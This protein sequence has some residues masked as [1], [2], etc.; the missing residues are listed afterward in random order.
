MYNYIFQGNAKKNPNDFLIFVKRLMP[1]WVNCI[2]DSECIAIFEI[3]KKLRA[4]KRKNL[5]MVETGCGASTIAMLVHSC[6]YGGKV[7]SW[8]INQ[9]RGSF[10]RGLFS[11]SIGSHF[12]KDINNYWTFIGFDSVDLNIGIPVLKEMKLKADF[13]FFDSLHTTDHVKKELKAFLEISSNNFVVAFDDAYFNKKHTNEGYI[14]MMRLKL[15]LKKMIN[16]KNNISKEIWEEAFLILKNKF[17]KVKR[18]KSSF[19]KNV[20][21]D[22]YFNYFETDRKF[23]LKIDMEEEKRKAETFI[24]FEVGR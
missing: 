20:K 10:L 3:L 18:I 21:K 15:K 8:D 19:E 6:I 11:E 5:I 16:F 14:N 9:S 4:K 7:F 13:G 17:R 23:T 2:P 12:E 24:A 1:R 22:P